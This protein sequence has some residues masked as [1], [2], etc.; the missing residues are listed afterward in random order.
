MSWL[1]AL[2]FEKRGSLTGHGS[3]LRHVEAEP[4]HATQRTSYSPDA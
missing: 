4:R 3:D 1:L 2:R